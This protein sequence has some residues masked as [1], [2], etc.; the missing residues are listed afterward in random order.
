MYA[1]DFRYK[2]REK[3]YFVDGHEKPETLA[4]RPVFTNKYLDNEIRA[5]RCWVQVPL[6]ESKELES[7]GHVPINCGYNYV[8]DDGIDMF[9]YYHVNS[10]YKFHD[11]LSSYASI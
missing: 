5:H 6:Q 4:Y 3:H 10:S 7:I 2:K 1:V 9:E 11:R 8:D